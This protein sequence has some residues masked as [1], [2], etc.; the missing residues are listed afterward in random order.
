MKKK[1]EM[2]FKWITNSE[3]AE[4]WLHRELAGYGHML[5]KQIKKALDSGKG[6][7]FKAIIF[8]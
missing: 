4:V 2:G 5:S 6:M 7:P 3:F 8:V 1:F